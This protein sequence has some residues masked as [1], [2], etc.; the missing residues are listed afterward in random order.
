MSIASRCNVPFAPR[1]TSQYPWYLTFNTLDETLPLAPTDDLKLKLL[2]AAALGISAACVSD[3]I[4]N[5]IRVLKT[6]RQT[7]ETT[8]TYKEAA[9]I[10]LDK[11]G[12][13]GLFVRGLGTRLFTNALQATIFTVVWKLGEEQLKKTGTLGF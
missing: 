4:S 13:S 8:I 5:S 9:K 11:D 1:V 12:W 6:T 2:R 10:V 7:S 3:C